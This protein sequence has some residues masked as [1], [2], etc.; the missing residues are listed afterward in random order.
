MGAQRTGRRQNPRGSG[1]QLR[2]EILTAVNRLLVEWGSVEKLT[3]RAVAAEVGV[4]APSVYLHFHDKAELVWAALT[5]KYEQLAARMRAADQSVDEQDP[6]ARL[7][8]QMHAY[9]RFGVENPGHYRL[10]YE[11]PQPQVDRERLLNHPASLVSG[12]LR[13]AVGRCRDSGCLLS[14]PPDQAAHTLWSGMHGGLSL[15]HSLSAGSSMEEMVRRL[16]DGLLDSVVAPAEV[17][18]ADRSE[19]FDSDLV[20]EFRVGLE[21]SAEHD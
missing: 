10:M 4:A 20:R 17:G 21:D 19:Q 14:L 12:L 5:D 6:L 16:A 9:C 11:L 8:A 18:F 2:A 13:Q 1:R 3:I 15:A 7:R